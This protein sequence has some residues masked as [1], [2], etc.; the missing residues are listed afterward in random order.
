MEAMKKRT[1]A[2]HHTTKANVTHAANDLL[3][4]SKRLAN[5]L[6]AESVYKAEEQM[7]H[8]SGMISTKISEKPLTSVLIAGGIGYILSKM[9]SK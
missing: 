2:V 4:E 8:Y 6:Y 9:F 5:E 3:T 1:K 7:K